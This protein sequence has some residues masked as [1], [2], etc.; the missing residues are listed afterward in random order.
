M[1]NSASFN[2]AVFVLCDSGENNYKSDQ[3]TAINYITC[4]LVYGSI[5]GD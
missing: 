4:R 5:S 2:V 1:S 3:N